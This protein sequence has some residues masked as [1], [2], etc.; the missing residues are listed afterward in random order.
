MGS[1]IIGG[2]AMVPNYMF[3]I[4]EIPISLLKLNNIFSNGFHKTP[5]SHV[6]K[7]FK[8]APNNAPKNEKYFVVPRP[9]V[10]RIFYFLF[11]KF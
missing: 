6:S 10:L 8:L 1:T 11:P 7:S 4:T 2:L 9:Q 3:G 5:P